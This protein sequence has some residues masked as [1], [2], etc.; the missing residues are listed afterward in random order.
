NLSL[1]N[2]T[3]KI[4][5]TISGTMKSNAGWE[6]YIGEVHVSEQYENKDSSN[7]VSVHTFTPV[8]HTRSNKKFAGGE[9][10]FK[11]TNEH[12]VS[13]YKWGDNRFRFVCGDKVTEIVL[14]QR[15]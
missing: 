7:Q 3:S 10:K 13:S 5:Y 2:S 6:P 11:F 12:T 9:T 14:H 8:M 15:K 1:F 4:S